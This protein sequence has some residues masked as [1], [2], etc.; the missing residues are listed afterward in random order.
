MRTR[1]LQLSPLYAIADVDQLVDPL[2]YIENLLLAGVS[3]LQLRSKSFSLT[4]FSDLASQVMH[5]RAR[6]GVD[7]LL[8]IND[9]PEVCN[10]T[11]ADGVHLGQG[12]EASHTARRLLGPD[13]IIGLSTHS[14]LQLEQA[15][16]DVLDYVAL[17]PIFPSSTKS[18]HAE[19]VGLQT[20]A[21]ACEKSQLPVVAIGG[22]TTN[23][24]AEVRR[25]GATCAAVISAL[26]EATDLN[27]RV[28]ELLNVN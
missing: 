4:Q 23:N 21:A 11:G 22:I 14:L 8:L 15:P 12:D 20:L 25:C 16:N 26:Q 9:Y 1:P 6:L 19:I 18:G 5:S 2:D 13:A 28:K 3:L 17:G 10:D 7:A 24:I 27:E